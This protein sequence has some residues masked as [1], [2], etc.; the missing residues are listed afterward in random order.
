MFGSSI[1]GTRLAGGSNPIPTQ[2]A[3]AQAAS[4]IKVLI[5]DGGGNDIIQSNCVSC[6]GVTNAIDAARMLIQRAASDG[7]VQHIVFFFYPYFPNFPALRAD[8]MDF[9]RPMMQSICMQSTVPCY[10][11]DLRPIWE[12]H[13]E[14]TGADNLH[15]S[16]TG[17]RVLSRTIW[18]VMQ[19]N[20]IAQ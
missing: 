15:P 1:S 6:A 14:Y 16:V 9:M 12:G 2:Y 20:C 4:P 18:N 10:F 7:T 11:I 3:N 19:Q 13:P 17:A 8:A 5:M